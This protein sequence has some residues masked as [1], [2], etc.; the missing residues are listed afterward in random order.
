MLRHMRNV[1]AEIQGALTLLQEQQ[2]V[3]HNGHRN[4]AQ[5][6]LDGELSV[7]EEIC[8]KAWESITAPAIGP[9]PP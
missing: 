4:S 1:K 9:P 6:V 8:R 2:R 5:L 7:V 3:G